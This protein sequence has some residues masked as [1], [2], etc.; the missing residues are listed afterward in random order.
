MNRVGSGA[1]R[2]QTGLRGGGGRALTVRGRPF[3]PQLQVCGVMY[4]TWGGCVR[5]PCPCRKELSRPIVQ[6]LKLE[7]VSSCGPNGSM[8]LSAAGSSLA[9]NQHEGTAV[10][11]AIFIVMLNLKRL[12]NRSEGK[13]RYILWLWL[14]YMLEE[15]SGRKQSRR[16][17]ASL[18]HWSDQNE[19]LDG[20]V[21]M[22]WLDLWKSQND[23]RGTWWF[24]CTH[25]HPLLYGA[26]TNCTSQASQLDQNCA[27]KRTSAKWGV[28]A[29]AYC[30]YDVHVY[31]SCIFCIFCHIFCHIFF[32]LY[33]LYFSYAFMYIYMH[34]FFVHL[35]VYKYIGE[36][37]M[38]SLHI[39][40]FFQVCIFCAYLYLPLCTFH[41]IMHI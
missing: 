29:F 41:H 6:R 2:I 25:G 23:W 26:T 14:V 22:I 32:F 3:G 33:I 37:R 34:K 28:H 24:P 36:I 19:I 21:P 7:I 1:R 18:N 9:W 20:V 17:C 11:E 5:L 12:E 40:A 8:P 38:G 35:D 30:A 31:I 15:T 13:I 4:E 39:F 10:E 27:D 16:A